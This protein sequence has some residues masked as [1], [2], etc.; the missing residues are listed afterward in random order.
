MVQNNDK[1]I[2]LLESLRRNHLIVE[3]DCWYSCP[4]AIGWDGE[5]ACCN[6]QEGSECNCGADEHNARLDEAIA[7][8]RGESKNAGQ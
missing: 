7:I 2:A 3:G 4:K 8:V 1:L 6:D 5:S